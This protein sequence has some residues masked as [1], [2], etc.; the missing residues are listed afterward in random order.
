[1]T[2]AL[3]ALLIATASNDERT[4]TEDQI[5]ELYH[6]TPNDIGE[7]FNWEAAFDDEI[8]AYSEEQFSAHIEELL[9]DNGADYY[10]F[11][12]EIKADPMMGASLQFVLVG[13]PNGFYGLMAMMQ[14]KGILDK[15]RVKETAGIR[16][17][18]VSKAKPYFK[19]IFEDAAEVAWDSMCKFFLENRDDYTKRFPEIDNDD[20]ATF[21][22][23]IEASNRTTLNTKVATIVVSQ[24]GVA[25]ALALGFR[26]DAHSAKRNGGYDPKTATFTADFDKDKA[27]ERKAKIAAGESAEVDG[28]DTDDDNS[29]S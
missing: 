23:V 1:M 4:I 19:V 10:S 20:I 8:D 16:A 27:A 12:Q 26:I 22:D 2:S 9:G 13:G 24:T 18:T 25:T 3:I 17:S 28:E 6:A 5:P 29:E 21:L 11:V 15:K 14:G 7:V